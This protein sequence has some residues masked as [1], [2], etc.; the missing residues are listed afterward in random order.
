MPYL[1][2]VNDPANVDSPAVWKNFP[3]VGEIYV[4]FVMAFYNLDPE[5]EYGGFPGQTTLHFDPVTSAFGWDGPAFFSTGDDIEPRPW[6][7]GLSEGDAYIQ[8]GALQGET[9]YTVQLHL[10]ATGGNTWELEIRVDGVSLT[11]ANGFKTG[12]GQ[13]VEGLKL[14]ANG[15]EAGTE[16]RVYSASAGTTGWGSNDIFNADYATE[17][18]A[19]G[20]WTGTYLG[21]GVIEIADVPDPPPEDP[22]LLE[23][24]TSPHRVQITPLLR[25]DPGF[26]N[27]EDILEA[28]QFWDLEIDHAL[29]GYKTAKV[30]LSMHDPVVEGLEPREFALRILYE[31]RLEPVF[32]GPC[33]IKDNYETGRCLLEAQDPSWRMQHHYLRRGDDAI[34]HIPEQDKGVLDADVTGIGMCVEAANNIPSQDARNDPIL[35]CEVITYDFPNRDAPVI[36]ERGQECWQVITELS[37]TNG[38]PDIDMET[39]LDLNDR[40]CYLALHTDLGVDRTSD[41]PDDPV[42]GQMVL[43]YGPELT[44]VNI[45]PDRGTSHAHVLSS[46]TKHR[47]TA[48]AVIPSNAYGPTVDWIPTDLQFPDGDDDVLQELANAHVAAYGFA[49][50]FITIITRPDAVM[51]YSYGN[52]GFV[53]PP[54]TKESNFYIGDRV[55]IRAVRGYRSHIGP[56]RITRVRLTQS[57]ARGPAQT[58][59]TLVPTV[60]ELGDDEE[61]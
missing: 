35:G 38:G 43:T 18:T 9:Q 33:N 27:P 13:T 42:E 60:G 6:G 25:S 39:N 46:D 59:L 37:K 15:A 31:D 41:T 14:T 48:G 47:R 2:I 44:G 30:Q 24:F 7:Y 58:H 55:T 34:T 8:D 5:E 17:P 21:S 16:W 36:V 32:W 26:I 11:T 45:D 23:S 29:G 51:P 50:K 52:P 1:S 22:P 40:Y 53:A 49:P 19:E 28:T 10:R 57:G 56:A 3:P 12:G 54:G 4:E 61:S 20:P